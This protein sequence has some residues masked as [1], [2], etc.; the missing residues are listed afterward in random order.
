MANLTLQTAD[1]VIDAI[2]KKALTP[3]KRRKIITQLEKKAYVL[4]YQRLKL[5]ISTKGKR[6]PRLS[7]D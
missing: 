7:I 6:F 5:G 1:I 2:V 4:M 3:A